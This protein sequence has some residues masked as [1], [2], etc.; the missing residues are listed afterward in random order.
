MKK[1]YT[2]ALTTIL[3]WS[4]FA[5]ATK[6]LLTNFNNI[7]VLCI[8]S[9][10]ASI[11]L[12]VIIIGTKKIKKIKDYKFKDYLITIL[13][14]LPGTFFYYILYYEGASKL[15]AS[16]AFLVN[17]MW[18]IMS[19]V[20]ACIILKEKITTQKVFSFILSFIGIMF[21][22]G[23]DILYFNK[24]SFFGIAMC[25]LAAVSYGFFTA[26]NKKNGYDSFIT[27][28][29]SFFTSFILTTVVIVVKKDFF[30]ISHLDLLGF[31]W[32]GVFTMAIPNTLWIVALNIG[33][34]AKI[35]NKRK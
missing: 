8:N 20:F 30:V 24:E 7:Q 21:I 19:V 22:A 10:I 34:T 3:L 16:Q 5:T 27:M 35:S 17:Y 25:F 18:P 11:I 29:I 33:N 15:P 6:L 14:G 12:F 4:T 9:L 31:L 23:S 32:S 2:L 1:E 28:M 26:L 13:M